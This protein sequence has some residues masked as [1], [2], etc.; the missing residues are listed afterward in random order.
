METTLTA[1]V[2]GARVKDSSSRPLS[3]EVRVFSVQFPA[4]PRL[5]WQLQLQFRPG[6]Q[7]DSVTRVT[8]HIVI[9]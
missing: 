5:L 4:V 9:L 2:G 3:Y 1:A 6:S 7:R 8:Q